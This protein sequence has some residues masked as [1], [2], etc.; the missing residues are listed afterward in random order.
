MVS[1]IFS[2]HISELFVDSLGSVDVTE[3]HNSYI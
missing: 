1:L 2:A 3:A